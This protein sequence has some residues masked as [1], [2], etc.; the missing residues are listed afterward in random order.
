MIRRPFTA[1]LI[2]SCLVGAGTT[3][4]AV[5]VV[6]LLDTYAAGR[7]DEVTV[8]LSAEDVDYDDV[9]EQ[10][11][12][13]GEAWIDR[14]GQAARDRRRLVAATVALEAARAGAWLDWRR[15]QKQPLMCADNG[16]CIQPPSVLYWGAPP[17]LIEWS[18]E[19]F[20]RDETPTPVERWWQLAALAV[21]ERSE[22]V[23]FLVGDPMIGRGLGTAEIGNVQ[24]DIK[25]LEHVTPR[26]P[27]EMRF[28]LAQGIARDRV[29]PD[30]ARGVYRALE[31]HP[32]VGGEAMMRLGALE[33]RS[34]NPG[35]ALGRFDR[36]E[37]L[38][39]DP[40]VI[41]LTRY[42]RGQVSE[43]RRNWDD[44]ERA[45]RGAVAAVPHAASAT[46]AL[47]AILARDGRRTE[48]ERLVRDM[49]AA[50]PPVADPWRGFVHADDRFWPQLVAR[51]R[52]E[53]A[54]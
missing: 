33:M 12:R 13:D 46:V 11:R 31:R 22:D 45:Y 16:E 8:A 15:T 6:A 19:L 21:A 24:D 39:R 38:T 37:K 7:F 30:E 23:Q 48:A 50:D 34:R 25:H 4:R 47:A 35:E 17:L 36:A 18:C 10:F 9:L 14:A 32:D 52:A 27:T 53:I 49:L 2:W 54:R 29:W 5:S 51:L 42:F 43:Q 40:Y 28:V 3:P 26:F 1:L 44:A 20:R 41:F